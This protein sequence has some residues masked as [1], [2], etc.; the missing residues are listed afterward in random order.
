MD[1]PPQTKKQKTKTEK[2]H[3]LKVV[4]EKDKKKWS[5]LE[6]LAD[7]YNENANKFIPD[8]DMVDTITGDLPVPTNIIEVPQM[9]DFIASM[10]L[11]NG[12]NFVV[13]KE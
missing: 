9:D 3:L 1:S 10:L 13:D 4:P 8:K 12:K 11:T 6:E 2:F 7:F 5:L